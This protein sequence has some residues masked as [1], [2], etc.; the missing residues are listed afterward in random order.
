ME[1]HSIK[2]RNEE[3][4][5]TLNIGFFPLLLMNHLT[6]LSRLR[7][8]CAHI[9]PESELGHTNSSWYN[10]NRNFQNHIRLWFRSYI[11]FLFVA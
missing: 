3:V 7:P 6:R 9:Q 10:R 8:E 1:L 5:I 4:F 2:I 11:L